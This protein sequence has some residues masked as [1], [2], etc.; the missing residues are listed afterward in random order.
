MLGKSASVSKCHFHGIDPLLFALGG[1]DHFE[2]YP[3]VL[4]NVVLRR[5]NGSGVNLVYS[6]SACQRNLTEKS[7]AAW[8]FL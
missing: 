4:C 5:G 3:P 8:L 6:S 2:D 7:H 1:T